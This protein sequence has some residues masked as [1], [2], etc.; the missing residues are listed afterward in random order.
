[1]TDGPDPSPCPA[2]RVEDG[3]AGD[4]PIRAT[5]PLPGKVVRCAE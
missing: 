4:A 5:T 2:T 1:M 3:D